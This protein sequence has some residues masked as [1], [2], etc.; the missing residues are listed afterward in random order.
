MFRDNTDP[1]DQMKLL[2]S[3]LRMSHTAG[4]TDIVASKAF[5]KPHRE[6]IL[7]KV[8]YR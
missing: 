7:A 5:P 1:K 3:T 6:G 2:A 8:R 4:N